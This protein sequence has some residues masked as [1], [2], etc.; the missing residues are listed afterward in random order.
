ML[1]LEPATTTLRDVV[2]AID[3]DQL[4]ATTPC[5]VPVSAL[6]LHVLGLTAAFREAGRKVRSPMTESAPSLG[7]GALPPDWRR[8][9]P[10]L[11]DDLVQTWREP[12]AWDG[13]TRIAGSDLPGQVCGIV[14]NNELVLHAWDLAVATGQPYAAEQANL[15]ASWQMVSG[16]P[17]DPVARQGLFGPALDVGEDAPL[18]DRVLCGAGRDPRWSPVG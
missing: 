8:Q 3:D 5:D 11:L 4:G 6:L 13:M 18:L 7:E 12:D 16:T 15:E 9:L 2:D 1:D 17:D 10:V 14:V